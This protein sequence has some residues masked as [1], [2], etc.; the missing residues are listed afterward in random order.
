MCVHDDPALYSSSIAA[1]SIIENSNNIKVLHTY[2]DTNFNRHLKKVVVI[3]F[4]I[5]YYYIEKKTKLEK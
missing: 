5:T 3:I 2:Y 4:Q 1:V